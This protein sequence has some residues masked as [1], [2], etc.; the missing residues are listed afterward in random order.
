[1]KIDLGS[2]EVSGSQGRWVAG[3]FLLGAGLS[4]IL[5]L[6]SCSVVFPAH[7]LSED[8]QGE[9]VTVEMLSFEEVAGLYKERYDEAFDVDLKKV[10]EV[11]K[12]LNETPRSEER[13]K[14]KEASSTELLA[15]RKVCALE[16][17]ED[18]GEDTTEELGF[19][20]VS[21]PVSAA[22]A[23]AGLAID[24]VI[25]SLE[26]ESERYAAQYGARRGFDR[27]YSF[28]TFSRDGEESLY[29][30]QNYAGFRFVRT[31]DAGEKAASEFFCAITPGDGGRAF[32]VRPIYLDVVRSKAKVLAFQWG[33]WYSAFWT[34]LLETGSEVDVGIEFA[35]EA[36]WLT[37]EAN[38]PALW[39]RAVVGSDRFEFRDHELGESPESLED[40][41]GQARGW[42]PGL[43]VSTTD[44]RPVGRGL[45]WIEVSATKRDPSNAREIVKRLGR[46]IGDRRGDLLDAIKEAAGD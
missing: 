21:A 23:V 3:A 8:R 5:S 17:L 4:L 10:V 1:M 25:A 16:Y 26:A 45:F 27:F 19:A 41:D 6:G 42:F 37:E 44:G 39:N 35:I 9:R 24:S 28:V 18:Y 20:G 38:E 31:T 13:T 7:S 36:M 15:L 34:W 14:F 22:S 12:H 30:I 46:E 2:G 11:I 29:R 32:M 43:P 40:L 33:S